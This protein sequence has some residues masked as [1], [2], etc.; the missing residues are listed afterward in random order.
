M[1]NLLIII[2]TFI[3]FKSF[4]QMPPTNTVGDWQWSSNYATNWDK[5]PNDPRYSNTI[6]YVHEDT[7]SNV[8]S[9]GYTTKH[10]VLKNLNGPHSGYDS[11]YPGDKIG[12]WGGIITKY[13][14]AGTVLWSHLIGVK[15]SFSSNGRLYVRDAQCDENG[16]TY[17]YLGADSNDW[18]DTVWFGNQVL[19]LPYSTNS[20]GIRGILTC[21]NP[22]GYITWV[23]DLQ[24][25]YLINTWANDVFPNRQWVGWNAGEPNNDIAKGAHMFSLL[26]DTIHLFL[27]V[28]SATWLFP[29]YVGSQYHPLWVYPAGAKQPTLLEI[30]A[31]TG[32]LI[33]KTQFTPRKYFGDTTLY[34]FLLDYRTSF[35]NIGHGQFA[36]I[37]HLDPI[38][39]FTKNRDS[40][41]P[42]P[43]L[44]AI[45]T[46]NFP[47][48]RSSIGGWDGCRRNLAFTFTKDHLISFQSLGDSVALIDANTHPNIPRQEVFVNG[49]IN[50]RI[51]NTN[52]RITAKNKL[53]T[54]LKHQIIL[55]TNGA[56]FAVAESEAVLQLGTDNHLVRIIQADSSS[57]QFIMGITG[58]KNP[59]ALTKNWPAYWFSGLIAP[60]KV[61]IQGFKFINNNNSFQEV[62]P[63]QFDGNTGKIINQNLTNKHLNISADGG[64]NAEIYQSEKG[65]IYYYGHIGGKANGPT[66]WQKIAIPGDD[67]SIAQNTWYD[68][69]DADAVLIKFGNKC[70]INSDTVTVAPLEPSWLS[71]S[72]SDETGIVLKWDDNSHT[73]IGYKIYRAV[74]KGSY[75][76]LCTLP[77]NSKGYTDHLVIPASTYHYKV[78]AYN[79]I[80]TSFAATVSKTLCYADGTENINPLQTNGRIYP[81]P[82]VTNHFTVLYNATQNESA[83][84]RVVSL[85]GALL[86]ESKVAINPNANS[87][88]VVLPSAT[89][90][91]TYLVSLIGTQTIYQD[92]LVLVK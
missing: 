25:D 68:D 29:Q 76:L 58:I 10:T 31:Q 27:S 11:I 38:L 71:A 15:K 84:L 82:S 92:K 40:L 75:T 33:T 55:G 50:T 70:G 2:F 30:T 83:I 90:A 91:G 65:N 34:P 5:D 21:I 17:I 44:D 89:P 74:N 67:T 39:W 19:A 49:A 52:K 78:Y 37:T 87:Y 26:N 48:Y 9:V 8:I 22:N 88:E 43:F 56:P 53:L 45:L 32:S 41:P 69:R 6:L 54:F 12:A 72:C 24:D 20:P 64:W 81:N 13:D 57:T 7:F 23:K 51:L 46:G 35:E 73:E 60:G 1:K 80:D 63:I 59:I 79:R 66:S 16:N 18:L 61:D 14:C 85:N 4:A 86:Y 42:T 3:T 62:G 36:Y 77:A 47:Q 28:D